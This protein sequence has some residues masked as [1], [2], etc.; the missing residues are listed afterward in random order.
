MC[1][2]PMIMPAYLFMAGYLIMR[3]LIQLFANIPR[4]ERKGSSRD[5]RFVFS[6]VGPTT[7]YFHWSKSHRQKD[8]GLCI[9]LSLKIRGCCSLKVMELSQ[10]FHYIC[11]VQGKKKLWKTNVIMFLNVKSCI[12]WMGKDSLFLYL[13]K[14][15]GVKTT[16]SFNL[17]WDCISWGYLG[18]RRLILLS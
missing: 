9:G 17:F 6:L 2:C 11:L 1:L 3:Q 14:G 15:L 5:L 10:T 7:P 12:K 13:F 4:V 18:S 8:L 16:A